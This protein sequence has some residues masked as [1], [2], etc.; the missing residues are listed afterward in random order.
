[1]FALTDETGAVVERYDY[2]MFGHPE[3]YAPDGTPRTESAVCNPYLFTGRRFDPETQWYYYRT[4][5][6]Q[7]LRGQFT[8]LDPLGIWGDPL[9][10][11]NG[12]AYRGNN[13]WLVPIRHLFD[14][15]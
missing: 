15:E 12:Y 7:P 5:Y 11:G 8:T 10:A 9:N 2:V 13:P 1:M 14:S 6:Y 3:F 4:R